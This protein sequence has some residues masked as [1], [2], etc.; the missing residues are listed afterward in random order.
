MLSI[1]IGMH[2]HIDNKCKR[3]NLIATTIS[4]NFFKNLRNEKLF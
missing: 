4:R 2:Q 3:K 1:E